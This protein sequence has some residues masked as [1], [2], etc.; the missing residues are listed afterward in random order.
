MAQA[1]TEA[2]AGRQG[3]ERKHPRGDVAQ[4][5]VI[6][7]NGRWVR[8]SLPTHGWTRVAVEAPTS[9]QFLCPACNAVRHGTS[10][11]LQ[12]PF[13]KETVRVDEQCAKSM[14]RSVKEPKTPS[15]SM[16][17]DR[18]SKRMR[19]LARAWKRT[20]EG[21]STLYA[22]GYR[23]VVAFSGRSW[24]YTVSPIQT[25][26]TSWKRVGYGSSDEAKL[27]AFD[28]IT[29]HLVKQARALRRNGSKL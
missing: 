16:D 1:R 22:D 7:R 24:T 21:R 18:A 28:E 13:C 29:K 27:A 12:H 11:L 25:E 8:P 5:P 20:A 10:H 17:E 23:V 9:G 14:Q 4:Y 3:N 2:D 15:V 19:W 6:W 26:N